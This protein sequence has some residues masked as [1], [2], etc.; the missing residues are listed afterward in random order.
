MFKELKNRFSDMPLSVRISVLFLVVVLCAL[1]AMDY[2]MTLVIVGTLGT[3]A[4]VGR[5]I[6]YIM[7]DTPHKDNSNKRGPGFF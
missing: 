5:V 1:L 3:I 7:F 4:A 6:E 2:R